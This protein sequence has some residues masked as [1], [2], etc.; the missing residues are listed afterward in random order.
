MR[1]RN[2]LVLMVGAVAVSSLATW[3]AAAQIRSP[4]EV[5]ARTAPPAASPILVPVV[6]RVLATRVVT[7]GTAHFGSP[8]ALGVTASS[9]KDGPRIVTSLPARGARLTAGDV[10]ATVSGR[11]VFLLTGRTPA[12]RD[13]GP[14]MSGRDVAQLERSLRRLGLGPGAVDGLFDAATGDAVARLYRRNGFE[15]VVANE[16]TLSGARPA[17]AGLVAGGFAQPG[18]QL[19]SDEGVFVGPGPLRV[20]ELPAAVGS[21][22]DGVLA[23]VTGSDV[24]ID[25]QL[26][27]E[28]A[29][30]VRAGAKVL[31]DEPTLGID[32]RG[33]VTSVAGRPGTDGADGFH[34][35]FRVTVKDPPAAL[36]GAS[37]RLTIPIRSTRTAQLTVPVTAVSL[38]PDGGSRVE[39]SEGGVTRFVPI[40][41][42]LSADGFVSITPEKPGA[43]AAGD[44]VVVGFQARPR[45]GG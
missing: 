7:R 2:L 24:V 41:T 28:Q 35:S 38:G 6:E 13:L 26:R 20:T 14:G 32:A 5:A 43:L 45:A 44:R 16:E 27:V 17:E 15:P 34:V 3:A 37:V 33:R 30:R 11:P 42:G 31:V 25:G 23:T 12:F 21:K 40:R 29:G 1:R 19:P 4:A 8:R 10:L 22:P 9:L 36:V 39:R 18:V